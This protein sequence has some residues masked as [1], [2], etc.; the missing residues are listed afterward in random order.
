MP[1][2]ENGNMNAEQEVKSGAFLNPTQMVTR[3]LNAANI[4]KLKKN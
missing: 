4:F 2:R 1:N 3:Q